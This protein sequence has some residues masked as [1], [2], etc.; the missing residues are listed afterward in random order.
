[1]RKIFNILKH[2]QVISDELLK[3]NKEF[4]INFK[5]RGNNLVEY[6]I[7]YGIRNN[8]IKYLYNMQNIWQNRYTQNR[9]INI[10]KLLNI[11]VYDNF[12]D[13]QFFLNIMITYDYFKNFIYNYVI[14]NKI[15]HTFIIKRLF[16]TIFDRDL[17][18]KAIDVFGLKTSKYIIENNDE[19]LFKYLFSNF[20]PNNYILITLFRYQQMTNLKY[21]IEYKDLLINNEFLV[22]A[23][24]IDTENYKY[25]LDKS[26]NKEINIAANKLYAKY[27]KADNILSVRLKDNFKLFKDYNVKITNNYKSK[28]LLDLIYLYYKLPNEDIIKQLFI[29]LE[30]EEFYIIPELS[31]KLLTLK[32]IKNTLLSVTQYLEEDEELDKYNSLFK[33]LV[34]ISVKC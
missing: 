31:N 30:L 22:E 29:N 6:L 13:N 23:F 24:Y 21:L 32:E 7:K 10:C 9:I 17:Q 15:F 20:E 27:S 25:F 3:N 1:M 19:A 4:L 8:L 18:R 12:L 28:I 33:Q 34:K 26:N 2:D 11:S 16:S 5:I 14:D